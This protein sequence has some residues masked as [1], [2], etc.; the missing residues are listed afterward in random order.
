MTTPLHP[1]PAY[2]D[3]GVPWLGDVPAH[4]QARRLRTL[5]N[6]LNGA[7]P[8]SND[9]ACWDG[10]IPWATPQDISKIRRLTSTARTLTEKGLNSCA[11]QIAPARSVIIT[12][13]APVGNCAIAEI[14]MATNQGCKTLVPRHSLFDSEFALYTLELMKEQLN[15]VA[16]GTTFREI[17]TNDLGDS[18]LP[19]PPLDEQQAIVR[20]LDH[21]D[22]RI[23]RFVRA[24]RRLIALLAEEKQA[25]IHHAVTRGLDPAAPR[26]DSGIPWL[27][28]IPAHWEVR[29]VGAVLVQRRELGRF[30]LPTLV[31]SLKTGVTVAGEV[32]HYGKPRAADSVAT[33]MLLAR[34]GDITYNM[35]RCWQGAIGVAPVDG[36]VSPAYVVCHPIGCDCPE[37]L[38]YQFRLKPY[39]QAINEASRGIVPDRNRLYWHAFKQMPIAIPPVVDQLEIVREIGKIEQAVDRSLSVI[40]R[41]I[42]LIREYRT[43]LIADIV[44]GKVD[45]RGAAAGLPAS[46]DDAIDAFLVGGDADLAADADT[47]DDPGDDEVADTFPAAGEED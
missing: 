41:E 10:G 19:L 14:P 1:Y 12:C 35:M 33:D 15:S 45:V 8:S 44:T 22:R 28:E 6:I 27:G 3:S 13:R 36:R 32:D 16:T 20:Y 38:S 47:P 7:T 26:K 46:G 23:A 30:A 5:G 39:M 17:S 9:P 37:Y 4:W 21:V 24:K 2:R 11:A 43:R 29:R 25:L 31:V 42:D 40:T 18:L 34:K